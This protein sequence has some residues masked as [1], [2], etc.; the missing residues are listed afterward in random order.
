[1][2]S[3]IVG[4]IIHNDKGFE[5]ELDIKL[6]DKTTVTVDSNNFLIGVK[7]KYNKFKKILPLAAALIIGSAV[8]LAVL[9]INGCKQ[10]ESSR[11]AM[12]SLK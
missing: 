10:A 3:Q 4:K 5:C 11:P 9:K 8:T 1:M 2:S 7:P 12:Q 6:D